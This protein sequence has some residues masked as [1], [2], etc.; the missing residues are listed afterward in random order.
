MNVARPPSRGTGAGITPE[1]KSRLVA[2]L[3]AP[4]QQF[5]A[6]NFPGNNGLLG[7][8]SQDILSTFTP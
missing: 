6:L 1:R 3:D 7:R 2:R 5:Q 4:S 8:M